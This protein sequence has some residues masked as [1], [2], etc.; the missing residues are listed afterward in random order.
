MVGFMGMVVFVGLG[1]FI[2]YFDVFLV[3]LD[4]DGLFLMNMGIIMMIGY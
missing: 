2:V 3:V 4:G 1:L